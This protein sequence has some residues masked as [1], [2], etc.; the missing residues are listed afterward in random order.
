MRVILKDGCP[1]K[2]GE[3]E[4]T[5]SKNGNMLEIK[6]KGYGEHGAVDGEGSVI[7][8]EHYDGQLRALVFSEIN[9]DGPTNVI[10]LEGARES[11]RKVEPELPNAV[12][13]IAM[14][15][16][17]IRD[18]V[19]AQQAQQAKQEAPPSAGIGTPVPRP[20]PAGKKGSSES[21]KA[22]EPPPAPSAQATP[23]E[24]TDD[25]VAAF[26]AA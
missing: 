2:K 4:I 19:A 17:L 8:L 13:S 22:T 7:V 25:E 18:R 11:L 9:T 6:A 24:P 14:T 10:G 20:K 15:G 3:A 26:D 5:I 23:S 16:D 1:R 12:E 21:A